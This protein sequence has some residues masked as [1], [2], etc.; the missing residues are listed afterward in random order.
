M[1]Q[2]TALGQPGLCARDLDGAVASDSCC[3][4]LACSRGTRDPGVPLGIRHGC[5]KGDGINHAGLG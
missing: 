2:A 4:L 5:R 1:T 3:L